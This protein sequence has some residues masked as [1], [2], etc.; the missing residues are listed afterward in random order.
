MAKTKIQIDV[1]NMPERWVKLLLYLQNREPDAFMLEFPDERTARKAGIQIANALRR[2]VPGCSMVSAQR[3]RRV[4]VVK[5]HNA[6]T[7]IIKEVTP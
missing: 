2:G 5:L 3:G 1:L 6:Q 4:F 7:V